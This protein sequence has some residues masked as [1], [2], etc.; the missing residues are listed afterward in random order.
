MS[1]FAR[2]PARATQAAPYFP[3]ISQIL[4][5]SWWNVGWIPVVASALL[6]CIGI[7][8]IGTTEPNFALRQVA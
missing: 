3:V 6:T 2:G 5:L 1:G 8:A 7:V 4:G